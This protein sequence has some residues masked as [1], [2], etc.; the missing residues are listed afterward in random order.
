MGYGWD[1]LLGSNTADIRKTLGMELPQL[2]QF[3]KDILTAY[4][5]AVSFSPPTPI[6]T[7]KKIVLL[8][9][10]TRIHEVLKNFERDYELTP[11]EWQLLMGLFENLLNH[12]RKLLLEG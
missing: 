7:E 3:E 12:E 9:N 2:T 6:Q 4:R 10:L 11:F 5:R 8:P 1:Y